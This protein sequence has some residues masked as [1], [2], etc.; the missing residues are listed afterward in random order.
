MEAGD[1]VSVYEFSK[2]NIYAY[3]ADGEKKDATGLTGNIDAGLVVQIP[4]D[5]DGTELSIVP[6][7][8]YHP[9][10]ISLRDYYID[11]DKT[12]HDLGGT[13]MINENE[14]TDDS[15]K[16]SPSSSY[17]ISYKYLDS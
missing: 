11:D 7:G 8:E 12:E 14:Y 17:I 6:V 4:I 9:K 3:D 1:D 16:I 15:V 2:F 13:W 10:E 5:Y